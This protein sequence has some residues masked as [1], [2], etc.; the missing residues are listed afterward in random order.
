MITE[1]PSSPGNLTEYRIC[2]DKMIHQLLIPQFQ[3]H[4]QLQ[5]VKGTKT[6]VERVTLYQQ[7]GHGQFRF[8][9][10]ENFQL[11]GRDVFSK[12]AQKYVCI[13]P[14]DGLRSYFDRKRRC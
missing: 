14:V 9:D 8:P 6:Q 13:V 7:L 10:R 5:G 3:C 2:R 12:L 1:N 11:P 4:R